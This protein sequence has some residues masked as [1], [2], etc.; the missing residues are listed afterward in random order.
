MALQERI[1][2]SIL[3]KVLGNS[4]SKEDLPATDVRLSQG[5][6]KLAGQ[7]HECEKEGGVE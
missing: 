5:W 7:R 3:F 1:G 2:R 4:V 6:T